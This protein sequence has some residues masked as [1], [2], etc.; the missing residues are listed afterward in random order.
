MTR[1]ELTALALG[2]AALPAAVALSQAA[3]ESD[4]L[5]AA[6]DSKLAAAKELAAFPLDASVEPAFLFKA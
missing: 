1:R 2:T 6:R 5:K 3:G 4:D